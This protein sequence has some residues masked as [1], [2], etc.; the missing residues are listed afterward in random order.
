MKRRRVTERRA[1]IRSP[2]RATDRSANR[3]R[4]IQ[5]QEERTHSRRSAALRSDRAV[6]NK[7]GHGR[8]YDLSLPPSE[9]RHVLWPAVGERVSSRRGAAVRGVSCL[10]GAPPP[11]SLT[12]PFPVHRQALAPSSLR[13]PT[14]YSCLD[15]AHGRD[16]TVCMAFHAVDGGCG[17][18]L[19]QEGVHP[20]RACTS[21]HVSASSLLSSV[22]FCP[23][24]S[25]FPVVRI[26]RTWRHR[27]VRTDSANGRLIWGGR[28]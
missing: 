25:P 7:P 3:F 13:R 15:S 22:F 14:A 1:P 17:V 16:Q 9:G 11:P 20:T 28:H 8:I 12:P 10:A 6:P 18:D 26:R 4:S 24:L 21:R 2:G 5:T 23:L 19:D 27:D